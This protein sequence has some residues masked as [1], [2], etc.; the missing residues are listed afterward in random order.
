MQVRSKVRG[1]QSG[2]AIIAFFLL[3]PATISAA[4]LSLKTGDSLVSFFWTRAKASPVDSG[5]YGL[6]TIGAKS[7]STSPLPASFQLLRSSSKQSFSHASYSADMNIAF[8]NGKPDSVAICSGKFSTVSWLTSI[9][10]TMGLKTYNIR[11]YFPILPTGQSYQAYDFFSIILNDSMRLQFQGIS[12]SVFYGSYISKKPGSPT[13]IHAKNAVAI[14]TTGKNA[15][16]IKSI[17]MNGSYLPWD[18]SYTG[19]DFSLF[20]QDKEVYGIDFI[21]TV[22]NEQVNR[23]D[24]VAVE[25]SPSLDTN[26]TYGIKWWLSNASIVSR[27]SLC[28]SLDNQTTWTNLPIAIPSPSP[29]MAT[30]FSTPPTPSPHCFIKIVTIDKFGESSE[31][32]SQEFSIVVRP[33]S[34]HVIPTDSEPPKNEYVLQWTAQDSLAVRLSWSLKN[35]VPLDTAI[36]SIALRYSTLRFPLSMKDT[37]SDTIG[38][39][40]M[41]ESSA[42]VRNIKHNQHYYFALFVANALGIWSDTTPQSRTSIFISVSADSDSE[43]IATLGIK[44]QSLMND[45]VTVWTTPKLDTTFTDILDYWNVQVD[46]NG[47]IQKSPIYSFRY[48]DMPPNTKLNIILKYWNNPDSPASAGLRLYQYNIFS[49]EWRLSKDS[50]IIDP[51]NYTLQTICTDPKL[52]FVVMIDTVAPT[53]LISPDEKDTISID[54]TIADVF[55]V[56][57]NIENVSIR[58]FAGAGN[59]PISDITKLYL[60]PAKEPN[61]YYASIPAYVADQFSGLRAFVIVDDGLHADTFTISRS[62][63]RL[64]V[65]CDDF[66]IPAEQWMPLIVTAQPYNPYLSAVLSPLAPGNTTVLDYNTNTM[67]IIQWLPLP[68]NTNSLNKWVEY[69]PALNDSF[70]LSPGRLIWIKTRNQTPVHFDSAV[71]PALR[72]TFKVLMNEKGWTDFSIPYKFDSYLGDILDATKKVC[73]ELSDSLLIYHWEKSGSDYVTRP[74]FIGGMNDTGNRI[75]IVQGGGAYSAFNYADQKLPLC[76]PPN[77]ILCSP[78]TRAK[79][80]A[81]KSAPNLWSV[82]IGIESKNGDYISTIYCASMPES[83]IPRY[84]PLPPSLSPVKT[85]VL[86]KTHGTLYGHAVTGDLSKGGTIFEIECQNTAGEF[87]PIKI[88]IERT[89]GIPSD[90]KTGLFTTLNVRSNGLNDTIKFDMKSLQKN[91]VIVAVGN[92][93]YLKNFSRIFVFPLSLRAVAFNRGIKLFYTLPY[94]AKSAKVT[95]YDLKGRSIVIQNI[96]GALAKEGSIVIN[97]S[98]GRGFYVVEL[99]VIIE[100]ASPQALRKKVVYV[101]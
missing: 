94:S 46:M 50:I 92:E 6:T 62:I 72:D 25:G 76:I 82:R 80:T 77:G 1:V 18:S 21:D 99:K 81:K 56:K 12:D 85:G 96:N 23:I 78:L 91:S 10:V 15:L 93:A 7:V 55:S 39:Y 97:G 37:L 101:R 9:K 65:N 66:V 98:I 40:K 61:T 59:R 58:L 41:S 83:H 11:F 20:R 88:F 73:G 27:C 35:G 29:V 49:G 63:R 38:S 90:M 48:G 44:P 2:A 16:R 100:G 31:A 24:S 95:L 51:A 4:P 70:S 28:V 34:Q 26:T 17:Q 13:I 8:A 33:D 67:R 54:Q 74:I 89:S 84:L 43:R 42:I 68:E 22:I 53:V 19:I 79:N 36:K 64:S 52:P 60:T 5:C 57:D 69:R 47:F 71:V 32:M 75:N 30:K 3:C 45:S 14:Q 86:D 87:R